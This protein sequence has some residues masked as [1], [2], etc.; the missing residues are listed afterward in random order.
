MRRF[1]G[2][3]RA[4]AEAILARIRADGPMSASDFEEGKSRTGW[5]E[6]GDTKKALEWLFWAGH[7]TTS[8]RRGSFERVYDLTERV[9]PASILGLPSPSVAEAHRAL[10]ERAARALGVATAGD[11]RD[12]FRLK[13]DPTRAALAELVEEGI[14]LPVRVSDWKSEAFLH[15]DSKRPRR[16]VGQALLAPFD[17]LVWERARTERLFGFRIGSRSTRPPTGGFT[18]ITCSRSWWTIRW[19][20]ES[21]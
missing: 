21:T 12:Y 15:R 11:L 7:V 16:I 3:A 9:I 2:E 6:W 10:V 5:W 8:T 4:A 1:A 20:P 14:L 19:S 17:P 18:V 13:P